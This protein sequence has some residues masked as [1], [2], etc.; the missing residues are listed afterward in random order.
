[1]Y[2]DK[3]N[4]EYA[5]KVHLAVGLGLLPGYGLPLLVIGTMRNGF[6]HR[7]DAKLGR[8]EVNNLYK[9]LPGEDRDIVIQSYERTKRQLGEL[10]MPQ[11]RALPPKDQFIFIAIG[12]RAALIIAVAEARSRK[13][14]A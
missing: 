6:A 10:T 7:A 5:Q 14:A 3:M 8:Q 4:L 1:M 13:N 12:L 2:I 9:S 11:L